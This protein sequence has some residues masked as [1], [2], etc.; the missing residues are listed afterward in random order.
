MALWIKK[1]Q[2]AED[3]KMLKERG[4]VLQG[5]KTHWCTNTK[6][7]HIL[8][9]TLICGTKP[10]PTCSPRMIE[11]EEEAAMREAMAEVEEDERPDD[12]SVEIPS[13]DE[14]H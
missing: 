3:A 5:L 11:E 14:Y 8:L 7:I 10:V 9:D 13:D 4:E 1:V 6:W 2:D 12:G